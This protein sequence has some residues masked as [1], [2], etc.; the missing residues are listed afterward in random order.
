VLLVQLNCTLA[1]SLQ[2]LLVLIAQIA[3]K[4]VV[5]NPPPPPPPPPPELGKDCDHPL[6]VVLCVP[7]PPGPFCP[8]PGLQ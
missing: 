2:N 4:I 6:Y 3:N 7:E 8:A 1:V 5:E